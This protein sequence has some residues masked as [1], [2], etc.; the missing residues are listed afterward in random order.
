MRWVKHGIV[1]APD[2]QMPWAR[3]HAMIP[4]PFR[5]NDEVIRVFF[6]SLDEQGLGRIGFIDLASDNPR[7]ILNVG[8]K[9]VF[10]EGRPGD[11][12]DHGVVPCAVIR[13]GSGRLCLFYVGFELGRQIRYRLLTGLAIS[14]DDGLSFHRYQSTPLLERSPAE[15]LFRCGPFC[16]ADPPLY[17]LWYVAGSE[18]TS[19]GGKDLPVYDIRYLESTDLLE[20]PAEGEVQIQIED[21]DEHGFGRPFVLSRPGGGYQ[22]FFSVRRRSLGAYRLAYAES[23]DGRVWQRMDDQLNLDVTP[24]SFD[25]DAIM[26]AAPLRIGSRL[27]LFYNGND[28]GRDG[29]ALAELESE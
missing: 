4:T 15:R 17:R 8:Q 16:L 20:W 28:F 13:D 18:W 26:Y 23:D 21:A 5:L 6:A 14:D 12:D 7:R 3:S 10:S 27:Y 2:G 9:P 29:L 1:Y 22:L 24:G 25:S 19:I 11:F